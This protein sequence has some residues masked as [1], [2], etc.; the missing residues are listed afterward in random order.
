MGGLVGA[1][2]RGFGEGA[3]AG[4]QLQ[5]QM[6]T[7]AAAISFGDSSTPT[8]LMQARGE[9]FAR[10]SLGVD[11]PDDARVIADQIAHP[12]AGVTPNQM[13]QAYEAVAPIARDMARQYGSPTRAAAQGGYGS[14]GEM[15]TALATER[16]H[17]Q[18]A[19]PAESKAGL[20]GM[21]G[22]VEAWTSASPG[23]S[24]GLTP[25][26]YGVGTMVSGRLGAQPATA[27]EWARTIQSL[28]Q[29]Y[30]DHMTS[31]AMLNRFVGQVE[32]GQFSNEREAMQWLETQV[33]QQPPQN[34]QQ[35][36][37]WWRGGGSTP[38][39][40]ASAGA[41]H[42]G[43]GS[44]Q[45]ERFARFTLGAETPGDVNAIAAKMLNAEGEQGSYTPN[46]MR[47]A[48][49]TI[50]PLARDMSRQYGSS[51]RAAAIGGYENYG[52][53]VTAMAEEHLHMNGVSPQDATPQSPTTAG[54]IETWAATPPG[55]GTTSQG[56]TPYDYG[57]GGF[58]AGQLDASAGARPEWARTMF[59]L[60]Q[61]Y[62][63]HSMGETVFTDF[64]QR[65][66]SKQFEN[67]SGARAWL[68][69]QVEARAPTSGR[70]VHLW[71]RASTKA[72]D[73]PNA[74]ATRA[75]QR[76]GGES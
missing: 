11:S 32:S 69:Q 52:Q 18:G 4:D 61:A 63:D 7:D 2:L 40:A 67:E 68:E 60:R 47:E 35:I 31:G 29:A 50:A 73:I 33:Q 36:D 66:G 20:S 28:R 55:Q 22:P 49:E 71:W 44:S 53:L 25:Y 42:Y 48:Y 41:T 62:G 56:I 5:H 16:L 12:P 26:D 9:R 43:A 17:V 75:S 30:G 72:G 39:Y 23:R 34:G 38:A 8:E 64:I 27:P 45:A 21:S 59:S 3:G 74:R 76:Q 14:Y 1:A 10:Y 70:S 19:V 54:P 15:A 65:V 58:V 24:Q 46:Q 51:T 6:P 57:M 13:R 37:L